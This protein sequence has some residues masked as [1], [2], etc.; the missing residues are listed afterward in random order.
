MSDIVQLVTTKPFCPDPLA[1]YARLSND[2]NTADTALFIN[3]LHENKTFEKSTILKKAA[4]RIEYRHPQIKIIALTDLGKM[5]LELHFG[6]VQDEVTLYLDK[7]SEDDTLTD[8]ERIC[9]KSA[10]DVL[11]RCLDLFPIH[12]EIPSAMQQLFTIFSFDLIAAFEKLPSLSDDPLKFPDWVAFFPEEIIV[13]DHLLQQTHYSVLGN[14]KQQTENTLEKLTQYQPR[15]NKSIPNTVSRSHP[16]D[17]SHSMEEYKQLVD[18]CKKH[19]QQGDIFQTVISRRFSLPCHQPLLAFEN[20]IQTNFSPYLFYFKGH[21]HTLFGASPETC[22]KVEKSEHLNERKVTLCPIAGTRPRGFDHQGKIDRDKDSRLETGMRLSQKE[23][24]E[25]MM[26]VDLA[27]ND[28]ARISLAGTCQV[29]ELTTVS[30]Y[31]KVMH[32]CSK[33]QGKLKPSLDALHAYSACMNMG[34]LSGAPKLRATEIL[35]ECE[36]EKRGP[37][38]G[39]I[40]LV[41]VDGEMDTAIIIRSAVVYQNVAHV[42]AGA[43]IVADSDPTLEALETQHKAQAVLNAIIAAGETS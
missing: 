33:V 31:A 12:Q 10:F 32:L 2:G 20:L 21:E 19:I 41:G 3:A 25:H 15:Q 7:T 16:V 37:Y 29:T 17:C 1:L 11:R 40:G 8:E 39:A 9:R 23:L 30:R 18:R 28:I 36:Q 24:A 27:R 43:G 13:I 34:T 35:R 38:G 42:R 5:V 4:L 14:D 26:L 22:V 6:A